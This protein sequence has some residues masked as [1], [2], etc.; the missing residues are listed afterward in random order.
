[1]YLYDDRL[2]QE[3]V[4]PPPDD[5]PPPNPSAPPPPP[6]PPPPRPVMPSGN[7]PRQP[8]RRFSGRVPKRARS[9]NRPNT[10]TART[11]ANKTASSAELLPA[12]R[13]VL[14]EASRA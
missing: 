8:G 4:A 2:Y 14:A 11:T 1:M 3:P 5:A 13:P 6:P 7:H 9:A 10:T 12:R